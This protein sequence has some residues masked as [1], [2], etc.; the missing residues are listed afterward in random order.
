MCPT[1][2]CSAAVPS[3]TAGD[4]EGD[5]IHAHSRDEAVSRCREELDGPDSADDLIVNEEIGNAVGSKQAAVQGVLEEG[6]IPPRPPSAAGFSGLAAVVLHLIYVSLS[7]LHTGGALVTATA[8]GGEVR[9]PGSC[10]VLIPLQCAITFCLD[11]VGAVDCAMRLMVRR[12][13]TGLL[14]GWPHRGPA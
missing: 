11:R 13:D 2:S 8:E 12:R 7:V 10:T 6:I 5:E 4:R 14:R 9:L 3:A 1:A